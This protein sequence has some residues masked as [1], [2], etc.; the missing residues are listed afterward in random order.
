[1]NC[2][3]CDRELTKISDEI[4]EIKVVLVDGSSFYA[5]RHL[6]CDPSEAAMIKIAAEGRRRI[7]LKR[8]RAEPCE[9]V[10]GD[11]N[12]PRISI[13]C[14]RCIKIRELEREADDHDQRR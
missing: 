10:D 12:E 9:C 3:V 13:V 2:I 7:D 14:G 8:V 5:Y 1:M 6:T 4:V 11:I